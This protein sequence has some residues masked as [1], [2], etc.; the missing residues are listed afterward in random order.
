MRL[1]DAGGMEPALRL[2]LSALADADPSRDRKALRLFLES[3]LLKVLGPSLLRDP[4]FDALVDQVQLQMESDPSLRE[5]CRIAADI[6][7]VQSGVAPLG[8]RALGA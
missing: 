5:S 3:A 7:L 6:M 2:R 8:S 1:R 4:G